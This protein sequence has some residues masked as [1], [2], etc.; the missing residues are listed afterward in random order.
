MNEQQYEELK[1]LCLPLIKW[2]N[3]NMH[4]HAK[5]II[6]TTCYELV[7]GLTAGYTTEFV[8]EIEEEK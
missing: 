4:P 2:L 6:D 1:A 8:K 7:E 3:D 5:I